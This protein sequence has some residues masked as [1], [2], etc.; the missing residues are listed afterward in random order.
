LDGVAAT[1]FR[2]LGP[3]Q[4]VAGGQPVALG[5]PKQRA[6]LAE[7]LL[8]G[9]GVVPR[10]RLVDAIWGDEPPTSA[11]A[12]LQVYVHG[13]RRAVGA[14]RIET[15]GDGYRVR[16]EPHELD[17]TQF[18]RLLAA[19]ERAFAERRVADASESLAA[20]LA[21]WQGAPLADL[22]DQPVA[23]AAA[24]RLDELR[25][26]AV[27]LRIDARLELGEHEALVP[28]LEALVAAEPYRERLREQ[29]VLALYRAGRQKDALEAYRAARRAL[30]DA[31]GVEPGPALQALERA[32][33][34]QDPD[35]DAPA[36]PAAAPRPRLPVPATPL[37]GRRLEV[38]AV[39]ALLRGDGTRLVTLTGPG[40][41]GKTRLALAVAE[42]RAPE[43]RDGAVF[44]D[45]SAASRGDLVLPAVA[46]AL[47]VEDALAAVADRALL[48]VLDNLEQLDD[49]A[50]V[51]A[52]LAAGPRVEVLATSRTPLR[53]SGEQEYPVPSLPVPDA[54]R[55][56]FEDTVAND[57]VRLFTARAQAVDP[58]FR[59]TDANVAD[60]A[61]VCRR[62]DGLPLAIELA[63]ARTK[64]LPPAAIRERLE[65]MLEVLVGGA[66]DL[67]ARQQTLRATLD[68]SY[69][70]LAEPEQRLLVSL[71]VFAGGWTLADADA[72]L[73]VDTSLGLQAL[74]DGGLVRRRGTPDAPRFHLLET[75]RA[76]A[77]ELLGDDP[78]LRAR[79]ARHF[80]RV[81]QDAW[82]GIRYGPDDLEA[83][84]HA[85]LAREHDNVRAALAWAQQ[86]PDVAFEAELAG[87]LRWFWLV[88]GH[89]AEGRRAFAALVERTEGDPARHAAALADGAV[90]AWRVG[91]GETAWAEWSTALELFRD[92]GDEENIARCTAELGAA[93]STMGD[94]DQ[95]TVLYEEATLLFERLGQRGR[96]ATAL[97]N[98]AALR[99]RKGDL[100]G[101]AA[102]GLQAIA[103]QRE[104]R[105]LD[106]LGV[107]LTNQAR[108]QLELGNTEVARGSLHESM[109]IAER[110]GYHMLLAYAL[111]AAA[112]VA[113]RDG[114]PE[115]A[116]LLIGASRGLFAS[117]GLPLPD[118]EAE[119]QERTLAPLRESL[120]AAR[121]EA[122]LAEG[123]GRP[124][125]P[126]IADAL[127]LTQ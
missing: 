47:G 35:L 25:L 107:A 104:L 81:A 113:R 63:A 110:I 17:L 106:G 112:E 87:A 10:G 65:S 21:L 70:L 93:A 84:G 13:L 92:L 119:D 29:Q 45:L 108:C 111:G 57:A 121:V 48:V 78:E 64:V 52:L 62:L 34:R 15:H 116:A 22:A 118:E 8:H 60:V 94:I 88:Q 83:Q 56:T 117:I 1:E 101:A 79:H 59:L 20:A 6:L 23:R 73:G 75:I 2:L 41:T 89:L 127:T 42:A 36:P 54:A 51:A 40:G 68:W 30:V 49:V 114:E 122:L 18:E 5:G 16:L 96:H 109:E 67:P 24:P 69:E 11:A 90:F 32:I 105:D 125:A 66:R 7:L 74:L 46:A 4:A 39:E 123:A 85:T 50:S 77:T 124:A 82:R 61:E 31:L 126:M 3:L 98:L 44:V 9:G 26:R 71:S 43:L 99:S 55:H 72:V 86:Q 58:E 38:A 115:R 102:V 120:T 14:D 97:S 95:A 33:L 12:S 27:E 28:E 19:A 103:I 53:L 37:V 100:E 80:D 76:Y 91:D